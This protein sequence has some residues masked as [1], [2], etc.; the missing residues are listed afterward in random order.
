MFYKKDNKYIKH[1]ESGKI[2]QIDLDSME[3]TTLTKLP[4]FP[5]CRASYY[6][7][8]LHQFFNSRDFEWEF[9]GKKVKTVSLDLDAM[10]KQF[11]KSLNTFTFQSTD[12]EYPVFIWVRFGIFNIV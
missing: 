3:V 6:R 8:A 7:F 5:K 4:D 11:N 10:N 9:E 12:K 2:E 1:Y